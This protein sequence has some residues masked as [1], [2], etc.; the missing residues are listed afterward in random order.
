[1]IRQAVLILLLIVAVA[2]LPAGAA[3]DLQD[4][5]SLA[6]SSRPAAEIAF[7][8]LKADAVIA[9]AFGSGSVESADAVWVPNRAAGTIV[10]IDAKDNTPGQPITVGSQPCASLVVAFDSVWVPLC[11]DGVVARVDLK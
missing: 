1:M 5:P 4:L 8:R 10:R 7:A 11:G 2:S 6:A 9:L 3:R